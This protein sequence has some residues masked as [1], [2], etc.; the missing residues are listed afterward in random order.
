MTGL[1]TYKLR[2]Y[3]L[4]SYV[5]V[6]VCVCVYACVYSMA[7]QAKTVIIVLLK[8]MVH[9]CKEIIMEVSTFTQLILEVL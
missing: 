6:C 7:R 5:C 8:V 2:V 9:G 1:Y 4:A 3:A